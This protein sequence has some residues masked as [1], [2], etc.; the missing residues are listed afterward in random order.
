MR[1]D[2]VEDCVDL[3]ERIDYVVRAGAFR[4]MAE[5][6]SS[7]RALIQTAKITPL[8]PGQLSRSRSLCFPYLMVYFAEPTALLAYPGAIA[9]ALIVFDELTVIGAVYRVERVEGV[10]PL[11]V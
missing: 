9:I 11:V 1:I 7:T 2:V 3:I 8:K 4:P 10:A 5:Y 6:S